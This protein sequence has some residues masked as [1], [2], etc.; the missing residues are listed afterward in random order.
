MD[1]FELREHPSKIVG[2]N[3]FQRLANLLH[4]PGVVPFW[5]KLI[6]KYYNTLVL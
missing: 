1:T 4:Q 5:V 2:R 3:N 6:W